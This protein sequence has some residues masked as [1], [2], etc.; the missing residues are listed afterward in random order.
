MAM[1]ER[2]RPTCSCVFSNQV[3]VRSLELKINSFLTLY[4]SRSTTGMIGEKPAFVMGCAIA[5][6]LRCRGNSTAS[7]GRNTGQ[8]YQGRF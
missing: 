7:V 6:Q 1:I 8:L 4:R 5:T 2:Y 3:Y